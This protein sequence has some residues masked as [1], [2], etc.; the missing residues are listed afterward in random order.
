MDAAIGESSGIR[1][2]PAPDTVFKAMEKLGSSKEEC[3]Y[4]GDS[5]VDLETAAASN[6]PCIAVTWGFRD[7]EYLASLGASVFADTP[8]EVVER[9]I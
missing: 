4:V 9:I 6:L 8:M 1:R 5:E 3:I 2:K 7:R